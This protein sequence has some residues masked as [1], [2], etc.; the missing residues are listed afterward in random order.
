MNWSIGEETGKVKK[1]SV[2]HNPTL[3]VLL[4]QN[5]FEMLSDFCIYIWKHG[6]K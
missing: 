4:D 5:V 1:G 6:H 2:D 3:V